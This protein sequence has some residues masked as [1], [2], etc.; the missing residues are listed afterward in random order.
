MAPRFRHPHRERRYR[1]T[2][3]CSAGDCRL[4]RARIWACVTCG[5]GRRSRQGSVAFTS[6]NGAVLPVRRSYVPR[7]RRWYIRG[8]AV[9][10]QRRA[11]MVG[12]LRPGHRPCADA[13]SVCRC[14]LLHV[15]VVRHVQVFQHLLRDSLEDRGANLSAL[16]QADRRIEDHGDGDGR[17][18]DRRKADERRH[19]LRLGVGSGRRIDLLRRAGLAGDG[20]AVEHGAARRAD[21]APRLPSSSSSAPQSWSRPRDAAAR[22]DRPPAA[23]CCRAATRR[24]R[25][26]AACTCRRWRWSR[27]ARWS[28]AE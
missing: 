12:R 20:V 16:M 1:P 6:A 10:L 18:V 25:C 23:P 5:A 11:Q 7:W 15:H 14:G 2:A 21:R 3:S 19:V 27:P 24:P 4:M 8:G 26:A 17:S 9:I 28:A 13:T 22:D